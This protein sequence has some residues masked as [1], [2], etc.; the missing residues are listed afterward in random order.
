MNPRAILSGLTLFAVPATV[1]AA[2]PQGRG[3]GP[4]APAPAENDLSS[5]YFKI[6]DWDG[7][8]WIRFSE[9]EQSLALDRAA[10]AL[11][12]TDRDGVV[13]ELE[14]VKRYRLVVSRGGVFAPPAAK[15]E[16]PRPTKK[17]AKALLLAYD[18]DL[19]GMLV[20]SE[21][22]RALQEA[23]IADP[24]APVVLATLDKDR[25]S[26]I[27][28]AELDELSNLLFPGS[29]PKSARKALSLEELFDRTEP[30]DARAGSTIGP[31]RT[32]GPI[33][34]YRRLDYDRS[35]G[36]DLADLEELQ[37]PMRSAVRP[38]AVL[39]TLDADGDGAIS[40]A[41]FA[42]AME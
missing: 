35:G 30:N 25:S 8:G 4:P 39:A 5:F 42:A 15:P 32:A 12:D 10:F 41:E 6:A 19:D 34:V 1:L 36:I 28:G 18:N 23:R 31:R 38:A 21:V 9:A 33:S 3:G 27:D 24:A 22:G 2:L 40:E 16:A 20:E 17:D 13:D 7:D 11:F 37:R 26:G 14:F 29:R